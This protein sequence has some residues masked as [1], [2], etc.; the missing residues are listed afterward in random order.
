MNRMQSAAP[1]G[2]PP[3][4]HHTPH[5]QYPP[6][7]RKRAKNAIFA[8]FRKNRVTD[9]FRA[10]I[11]SKESIFDWYRKLENWHRVD[12]MCGLLDLC[13]PF[14]IRYLGT[15]IEEIGRKDYAA[16][17]AHEEKANQSE[18]RSDLGDLDQ[19]TDRSRLT[20]SLT[21]LASGNSRVASVIYDILSDYM[22]TF[23]KHDGVRTTTSRGQFSTI[24]EYM[25]VLIL[26]VSHP[27]FSIEQK[28]KLRQIFE[29]IKKE[30]EQSKFQQVQIPP[31]QTA[32]TPARPYEYSP[33][34]QVQV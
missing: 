20:I 31:A 27:A 14:E 10:L 15:F 22:D 8:V 12:F 13:H 32:A 4:Y 33:V 29:T 7:L 17:K 25:L 28:E 19:E 1:P 11:N 6:G 3:T 16:L 23:L 26:A 30:V 9:H 34:Y 18:S 5:H 2:P 21:L 24:Q